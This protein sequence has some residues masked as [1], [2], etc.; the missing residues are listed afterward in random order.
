MSKTKSKPTTSTTTTLSFAESWDSSW[1]LFKKHWGYL[2]ALGI[3]TTVASLGIQLGVTMMV[4]TED[5]VMSLFSQLFIF[6]VNGI[7]TLGTLDLVLRLVKGETSEW[8]QFFESINKTPDF[9]WLQFK[10]GL[11]VFLG[12]LCFI[13]PGIVFAIKYSLAP[14]FMIDQGGSASSAL[15]ASAQMTDGVKWQ[16]F[17]AGLMMGL[18]NFGGFLL[19]GLGLLVTIPV[20]GLM[21]FYFY[22][23]L[24]HKVNL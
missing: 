1:A 9:L 17:F 5:P 20:T 22:L 21:Y 14:F 10:T 4:N 13:V 12:F 11:I 23:N 16:L 18:I 15:K 3:V 6:V 19:L 2:Y 7:I 24:R 8:G